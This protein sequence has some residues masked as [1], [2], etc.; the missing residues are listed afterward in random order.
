LKGIGAAESGRATRTRSVSSVAASSRP[1]VPR[2]SF[3]Q[4]RA[5][6][7]ANGD[8]RVGRTEFKGPQ[9]LF[10]RL[11]RNRDGALTKEDFEPSQ[12]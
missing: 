8:G 5:R 6:E 4:I 12:P 2:P 11:D 9:P 3:E 10:D 1:D 7:D